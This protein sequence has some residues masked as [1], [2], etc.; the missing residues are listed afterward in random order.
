MLPITWLA[1][2]R[3]ATERVYLEMS[4]IKLVALTLLFLVM[5]GMMGGCLQQVA[6][7]TAEVPIVAPEPASSQALTPPSPLQLTRSAAPQTVLGKQGVD[8][9]GYSKVELNY[10]QIEVSSVFQGYGGENLIRD[11]GSFWHIGVPKESDQAWAIIDLR[12]EMQLGAVAVRP[13]SDHLSHLWKGDNAA[14]EG[15]SDSKAWD[16]LAKLRLDHDALNGRDWIA[17]MLPEGAGPYRYHRI[18]INDPEFISM[19]GLALYTAD[20]TPIARGHELADAE[21]GLPTVLGKQ[22]V[23]LSG[24]RKVELLGGQI[25]VSSSME[26]YGKG[27]LLSDAGGATFWHVRLPKETDEA[28]VLVDLR[29]EGTLAALG[30]R[31]RTDYLTHLWK[32]GS[33]VLQGSNNRE[34]W[35]P[36]VQFVLNHGELNAVDWIIFVLPKD[37]GPYRYYRLLITGPDFISMGGFELYRQDA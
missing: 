26:N 7:I 28:W 31:P 5:I 24:F 12:S 3:S 13:R 11:T 25:E 4:R 14:L 10:D 35:V 37:I 18:L 32:G 33:A 16:T 22:G 19:A 6:R 9:G 1:P 34:E 8:L 21:T 29:S 23:D 36:A 15:S 30:I 17:F 2:N 27:N 20:S